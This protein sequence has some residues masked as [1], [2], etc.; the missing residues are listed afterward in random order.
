MAADGDT[1]PLSAVHGDRGVPAQPGAVPALD[2]LIAGEL[3]LVLRE[4]RVDV[5]GRRNHRHAE[6]QFLGAL[7]KAQHDVA[8]A[9][10]AMCRNKSIEGFLPFGGLLRV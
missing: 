4:N 10:A 8:C 9:L 7:E 2:L 1:G 3:R 5:V 6:L